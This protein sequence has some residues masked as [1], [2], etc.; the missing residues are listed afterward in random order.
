MA[1]SNHSYRN[2]CLVCKH[3]NTDPGHWICDN[4]FKYIGKQ[5]VQ[6]VIEEV[7]GDYSK[8][9]EHI[10]EEQHDDYFVKLLKKKRAEKRAWKKNQK[11]RIRK[12]NLLVSQAGKPKQE[13]YKKMW[14]KE[15]LI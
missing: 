7:G 14:H 8:M 11:R 4:C 13:S 12:R 2:K 1:I 9:P 10:P 15:F 6:E 3:R 5:I